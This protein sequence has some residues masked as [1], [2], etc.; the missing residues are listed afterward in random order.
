[1][2]SRILGRT[3]YSVPPICFGTS[4][5]GL[6]G[7]YDG[8]VDDAT[9]MET[10]HAVLDSPFTFIDTSNGYGGSERLIG[11]ALAE[12][13]GL[14]PGTLLA[15]KVDPAPGSRDLSGA[16]VRASVA[17]SLERLGLDRLE[18]VHF[19]DP[20]RVGFDDA[21]SADGA[22]AA[23]VALRE[24]GLISHLGVAGFD[25]ATLSRYL[26]TNLFDV[27]LIHNQYTL[28][29]QTAST[30]FDEAAARGVA[31]LNAAPY[32]GGMLAKGPSAVPRYCYLIDD[33][34]IRR[35]AL[36]MD[37]LCREAGVPLAAAALQFSL[38]D[39]R[40]TSTV[41]GVGRPDRVRETEHLATWEVPD[42]LWEDLR[43]LTLGCRCRVDGPFP[44]LLST[45]LTSSVGVHT[46]SI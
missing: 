36:E 39:V 7:L 29:C 20:E 30:L 41:V 37:A 1:M 17:E 38:R 43:P 6:P 45:L 19:H 15:T 27:V 2:D 5:L 4:P 25:S 28:I 40:I 34:D 42:Q 46:G 12:R 32:G 13:G 35:R 21:M 22:V 44:C 14:P 9:A 16:R 26:A 33:D 10:I 23:L 18:L 24:D 8:S 3:G 31:V 11:R